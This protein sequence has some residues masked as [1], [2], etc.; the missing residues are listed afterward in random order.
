MGRDSSFVILKLWLR[1]TS[2]AS[3]S[4]PACCPV[5][6]INRW[7]CRNLIG[8]VDGFAPVPKRVIF[9]VWFAA[10]VPAPVIRA[11][12]HLPRCRARD[13]R[14]FACA[15][16]SIALPTYSRYSRFSIADSGSKFA[17]HCYETAAD[18]WPPFHDDSNP[19]VP[20]PARSDR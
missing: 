1:S 13:A 15:T 3:T 19:V 9:C 5:A 10:C 4:A 16:F 7:F 14:K 2:S 11:T 17:L 20:E 18:G 8:N 12:C 6:A